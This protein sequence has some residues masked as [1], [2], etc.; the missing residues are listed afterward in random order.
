MFDKKLYRSLVLVG[1]ALALSGCGQDDQIAQMRREN[2]FTNLPA[3]DPSTILIVT[4]R[5]SPV[6]LPGHVDITAMPFWKE[7]LLTAVKS[8]GIIS[9]FSPQQLAPW[10]NNG[11]QIAVAPLSRWNEFWDALV[12][13]GAVESTG[14]ID[15]F[16]NA[17]QAAEYAGYWVEQDQ[18]VFVISP[19]SSLRGYTLTS[20]DCFFRV[21]CTPPPNTPASQVDNVYIKI[22]PVFRSAIPAEQLVKTQ[23]GYAREYPEIVFDQFTLS[24]ILQNDYFICI[25]Y[26]SQREVPNNLG[27]VFLARDSGA[28]NYQLLLALAPQAQTA[29]KI[30]SQQ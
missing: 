25:A 27:R 21:N 7:H 28:D 14:Q 4:C 20:G 11:M 1:L 16:H 23:V 3:K 5:F 19:G 13:K 22:A 9:G 10:H 18:S 2:P 6:A 17:S 15:V 29:D 24:G 12:A 26:K 8:P 30:E